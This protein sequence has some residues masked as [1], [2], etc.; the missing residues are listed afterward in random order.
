MAITLPRSGNQ[1]LRNW[2]RYTRG[3]CSRNCSNNVRELFGK[4][5][6]IGV[7][8]V[9][10]ETIRELF[11]SLRTVRDSS[12]K[13]LYELSELIANISRKY[14]ISFKRSP[15]VREFCKNP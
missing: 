7:R 2:R 12:P 14:G 4:P 10:C 13:I 5:V 8:L 15:K 11:R 3:L 9:F 6:F 1:L